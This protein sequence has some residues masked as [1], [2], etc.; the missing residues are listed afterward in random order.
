MIS[1]SIKWRQQIFSFFPAKI[2]HNMMLWYLLNCFHLA[3]MPFGLQF[4]QL[5]WQGGVRKYGLIS[6]PFQA[7]PQSVRNEWRLCFLAREHF[8]NFFFCWRKYF[9]HFSFFLIV[10]PDYA[11]GLVISSHEVWNSIG[12]FYSSRNNSAFLNAIGVHTLLCSNFE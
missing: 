12:F 10:F 11:M 5:F 2:F 6:P 4:L 9:K 3:L 1:L 8:R 7:P